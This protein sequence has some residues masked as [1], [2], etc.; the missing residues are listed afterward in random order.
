MSNTKKRND[1]LYQ[2][3][4]VVGRKPDGSYIRKVVYGKTKK[5]LEQKAAEITAEVKSGIAVCDNGITF[6]ELADIWFIQY[7]PNAT[8]RWKFETG[9]TLKKHL[10]YQGVF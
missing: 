7:N 1:G 9:L 5:E 10:L 8:E 2:K 3:T 4:I 6:R